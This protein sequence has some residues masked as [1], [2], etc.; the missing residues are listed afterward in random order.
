M[1][2]RP[3]CPAAGGCQGCQRFS[4]WL[5]SLLS[6]ETWLRFAVWFVIGC[7]VYFGCSIRRSVLGR[8]A[9]GASGSVPRAAD[10][11]SR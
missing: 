6:P 10:P 1:R 9:A 8:D 3:F 4:L 5:I 2:T 7:A 11:R